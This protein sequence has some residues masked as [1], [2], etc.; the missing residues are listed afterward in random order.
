MSSACISTRVL[1]LLAAAAVT[2]PE[3]AAQQQC[4]T[5][6]LVCNTHVGGDLRNAFC[7][8]STGGIYASYSINAVAGETV[9]IFLTAYAF[10][11]RIFLY[12]SSSPTAV[13][14]DNPGSTIT[15]L[16]YNIP[17]NGTYYLT[18]TSEG[19]TSVTGSYIIDFYCLGGCVGPTIRM[20]AVAVPPN[21]NFGD[22]VTL[23][24]A[25][26][27]TAPLA[28]TWYFSS[29]PLSGIGYA[30]TIT[31]PPLLATST[32]GVRVSNPCGSAESIAHVTVAPAPQ[33]NGRR[34][35]VH[36]P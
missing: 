18:V 12:N 28:Y 17:S 13:A 5:T 7:H 2:V 15:E 20:P 14:V 24:V 8:F 27:G 30:A 4:T 6:P 3:I 36:H 26:D 10:R 29:D 22:R 1:L 25:A 9:D 19:Y 21:A 31:S 23:S 35:A 33:T 16:I 34:R 32:F 11:P